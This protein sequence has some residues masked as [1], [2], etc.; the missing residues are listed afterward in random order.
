[1]WRRQNFVWENIQ[2]KC[3][4]QRP[5]INFEKFIKNLLKNLLNSLTLLKVQFKKIKTKI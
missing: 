3:T 1:M 2:Q 4:H 5:L